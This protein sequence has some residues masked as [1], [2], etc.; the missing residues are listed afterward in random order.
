MEGDSVKPTTSAES[1]LG[2][3]LVP[4]SAFNEL[5]GAEV[6]LAVVQAY[7]IRD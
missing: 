1:D 3:A 6:I 7:D 2:I 4:G 5:E